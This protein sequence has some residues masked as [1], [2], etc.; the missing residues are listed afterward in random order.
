MWVTT[1]AEMRE[2]EERAVANG[3]SLESLMENA[4]RAVFQALQHMA[5]PGSTV[6][7]VC[8]KG[9]NGGDGLVVARLSHDAGYNVGLFI[10]AK[11]GSLDGLPA[12]MLARALE[13]G[14]RPLYLSDDAQFRTLSEFG[15]CRVLVDAL[16]GTGANRP[17]EGP[18]KRCV[19]ACSG[20]AGLVLSIDVPSGVH[21]DTGAILGTS[22]RATR[23]IVL[24]CSKPY[25]FQGEGQT[26][27]GDWSVADIG[28]N[29]DGNTIRT[30]ARL[31]DVRLPEESRSKASHK[32]DNG[33]VLIVAG[34]RRYRGA[35]VLAAMGAFRAG[36]GLVTVASIEPVIEAVAGCFPEVT[37]VPLPEEQGAISPKAADILAQEWAK[38]TV[39][40]VG[41]GLTTAPGVKNLLER[42][43]SDWTLPTVVDAD[44]LN[45]VAQGVSLPRG[46][47]VLTP[48]PGEA[49][50]LLG[51]D[52]TSVEADRFS[53]ARALSKKYGCAV[54]LKGAFSVYAA[55]PQDSLVINPT[56]NSGMAAAGMGDVLSGVI[57]ATFGQFVT[58]GFTDAG[59]LGALW[60]GAAGDLAAEEI[61]KIGYSASQLAQFLP[62]ARSNL[63]K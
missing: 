13:R 3:A 27:A 54:L 38:H 48:H 19:E 42:L 56:G 1:A 26:M 33:K 16:L 6:A 43:W 37:F 28:L 59:W 41:P 49:G 2:L 57:A 58:H 34:S 40:V 61:G 9:N 51:I 39:A 7:V 24:G 20:F 21:C 22:I 11:E 63:T 10:A 30:G 45:L 31:P 23:T 47:C 44:A 18:T 35:A 53:A 25:L 46:L 29:L 62:R 5:E 15:N 17:L 12:T 52:V 55:S 50:R 4:G 14:L 32:G 60:H 8:G 36:S